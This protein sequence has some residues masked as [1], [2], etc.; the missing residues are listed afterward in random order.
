MLDVE[1][2]RSH[3]NK[4]LTC[5]EKNYREHKGE[6]G[7]LFDEKF[8]RMWELYLCSCA[9]A[10]HNGIVDLH[11]ILSTQGINNELEAIRWY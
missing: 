9:A 3:Y 1:N 7:E 8:V 10:F 5:W 6:V 2:L 11:Q 4:T